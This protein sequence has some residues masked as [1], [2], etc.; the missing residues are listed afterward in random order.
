MAKTKHVLNVTDRAA[1]GSAVARRLRKTGQ[2]PAV[3]YTR[4][5]EAKAISVPETEWEV[6]SR[7]DVNLITLKSADGKETLAL[8]KEVQN[9]FI[10]NATMHLDFMAVRKDQVISAKVGIHAGH[11]APAGASAG[12]ILDQNIHEVEVECLPDDMPESIEVDVSALNVGDALHISEIPLPKGVK[13]LNHPE[14]VV[15]VVIDPNAQPEEAPAEAAEGEEGAAA[16]PEIVGAKEK[17][18]KAAA[19]AAE[20]EE[21]KK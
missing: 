7:H 12:G 15:F 11:A 1:G 9:D 17:A 13:I 21:K 4:G 10:R 8:I 16:E 2:I 6:L 3:V 19:A 5:E 20:K 14:L 18:E